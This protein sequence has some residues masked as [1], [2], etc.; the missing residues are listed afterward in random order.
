MTL[1]SFVM[2]ITMK[3]PIGAKEFSSLHQGFRRINIHSD[4]RQPWCEQEASRLVVWPIDSS[5]SSVEQKTQ[6]VL[7]EKLFECCVGSTSRLCDGQFRVWQW[8]SPG[9]DRS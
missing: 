6:E 5:S 1:F 3:L 4:Q 7:R 9:L 8:Q 2:L